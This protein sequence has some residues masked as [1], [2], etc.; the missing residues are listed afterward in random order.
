MAEGSSPSSKD[1]EKLDEPVSDLSSKRPKLDSGDVAV[2]AGETEEGKEKTLDAEVKIS[3]ESAGDDKIEAQ[4]S[5]GFKPEDGE[6]EPKSCGSKD[7]PE[8]G[9]DSGEAS[10]VEAVK[11]NDTAE[12]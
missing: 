2:P 3:S 12:D 8:G 7:K 10:Q 6:Q 9:D 4:N 5:S 11:V 1:P